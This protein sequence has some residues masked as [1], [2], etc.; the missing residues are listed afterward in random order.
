[1]RGAGACS[2][3]PW[4][5]R[6]RSWRGQEYLQLYPIVDRKNLG[7]F[8]ARHVPKVHEE[9][10]PP[11]ALDVTAARGERV[12]EN[13]PRLAMDPALAARWLTEYWRAYFAMF[14]MRI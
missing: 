10:L 2:S 5:T 1:M 12:I 11:G 13:L 7:A 3:S 8:V 4:T 6:R 14:G 9:M